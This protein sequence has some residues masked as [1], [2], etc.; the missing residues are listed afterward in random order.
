MIFQRFNLLEIEK[1]EK[2]REMTS[3]LK[4]MTSALG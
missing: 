3:A 4:M 2:E 1:K